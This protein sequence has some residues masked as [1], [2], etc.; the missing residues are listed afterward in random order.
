MQLSDLFRPQPCNEYFK[1]Q[2]E[3]L[4]A[5][6]EENSYSTRETVYD[7]IVIMQII[8]ALHQTLHEHHLESCMNKIATLTSMDVDHPVEG[9]QIQ[10]FSNLYHES[11]D[12]L[13]T[14]IESNIVDLKNLLQQIYKDDAIIP[15]SHDE[16]MEFKQHVKRK[17]KEFYK[18][19]DI[20]CKEAFH[21]CEVL[22]EAI[23]LQKEFYRIR[24][25]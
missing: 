1:S 12:E 14:I 16:L 6:H 17:L 19:R 8:G 11:I 4:H 15:M 18:S 13:K 2:C 24:S 9:N 10:T 5:T 21:R 22:V 25:K 20:A 7:S 3:L 23:R